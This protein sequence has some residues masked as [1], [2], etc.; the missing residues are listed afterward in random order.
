MR[1]GGTLKG[2]R[3]KLEIEPIPMS[4]WGR[5]LA[6][7]LPKRQWDDLRQEVYRRAGYRCEVCGNRSSTLHAHEVWQF[8]DKRAIQRLIGFECL[9]EMCHN[10]KHF[11]RSKE[12]YPPVYVE[13]LIKHWCEVNQ[14]K[15][16][17]FRRHEAMIFLRNKKRADKYY[18][19]KIGRQ[20]LT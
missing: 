20:I 9:C 10:V 5:S 12:V 8:D 15:K 17:D 18:V 13:Q 3:L 1:T 2:T 4:S 16:A 19:V 7:R 14:K 6:N 11:G